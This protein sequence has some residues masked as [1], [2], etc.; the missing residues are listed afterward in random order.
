MIL[1]LKTLPTKAI[2]DIVP[3]SWNKYDKDIWGHWGVD[4][5]YLNSH[6]VIPVEQYYVCF[7][8]I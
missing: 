2:I 4:L 8:D 6:F 1:P 3:R 5:N 7:Y